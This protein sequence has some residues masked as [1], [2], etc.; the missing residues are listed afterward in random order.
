MAEERTP[1]RR[2]SDFENRD[3]VLME[4]KDR[5]NVDYGRRDEDIMYR[6]TVRDEGEGRHYNERRR[7]NGLGWLLALLILLLLGLGAWWLWSNNRNLNINQNQNVNQEFRGEQR[8]S[9]FEKGLPAHA[10]TVPATPMFVVIQT[11]GTAAN[12]SSVNI[13]RDNQDF[14]TGST[15]V[16]SEGK[17]LRRAMVSNAPEGIYTVNYR[18][19]GTDA[20]CQ[21]GNFQ[22]KVDKD[23]TNGFKDL[24]N[25]SNVTV[26]INADGKLDPEKII[27]SRGTSITWKNNDNSSHQLVPGVV[28]A[29]KLYPNL[30]RTVNAN[31]TF[32]LN[33]SLIGWANYFIKDGDISTG[34]VIVR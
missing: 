14:G 30:T 26:N 12:E 17:V 11:K 31:G 20:N 24:T 19:C 27:V 10:E 1:R 15:I 32:S 5:D 29:E 9:S 2:R 21:N 7:N 3:D 16:E 28:G 34:Q 23:S 25:Q 18:I 4:R 33:A 22:F 13:N 6:D 8:V